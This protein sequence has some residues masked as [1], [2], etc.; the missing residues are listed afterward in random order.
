MAAAKKKVAKRAA[1]PRNMTKAEYQRMFLHIGKARV[2]A[3]K[4]AEDKKY[5][6]E[7]RRTLRSFANKLWA[8]CNSYP[9]YSLTD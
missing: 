7:V 2:M 5:N 6:A 3:Q 1:Q 4:M 9:W 8:L